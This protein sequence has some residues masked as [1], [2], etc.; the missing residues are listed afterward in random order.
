MIPSNQL[1]ELLAFGRMNPGPPYAWRSGSPR[2]GFSTDIVDGGDGIFTVFIGKSSLSFDAVWVLD[3]QMNT[4]FP[5]M[6]MAVRQSTSSIQ[7]TVVRDTGAALRG[8]M[9]LRLE[10][11]VGPGVG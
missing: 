5:G 6:V 9:T 4:G 10:Q 7:C 2:M 11:L 1:R 3:V 8:A